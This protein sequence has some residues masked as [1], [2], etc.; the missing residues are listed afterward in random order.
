[1]RLSEIIKGTANV[2]DVVAGE[3]ITKTVKA[4][5]SGAEATISGLERASENYIEHKNTVATQVMTE[6]LDFINSDEEELVL[7]KRLSYVLKLIQE[8]GVR[9]EKAPKLFTTNRFSFTVNGQ[10]VIIR[11]QIMSSSGFS[12][13]VILKANEGVKQISATSNSEPEQVS[14]REKTE[15]SLDNYI[16]RRLEELQRTSKNFKEELDK[17]NEKA[18][19]IPSHTYKKIINDGYKF[20]SKNIVRKN[21]TFDDYTVKKTHDKVELIRNAEVIKIYII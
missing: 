16:D 7:S 9:V 10:K 15:E 21:G 12:G 19:G 4:I 11:D 13:A 3:A 18:Y 14:A 8:Q 6:I 17:Q 5:G 2:I 20:L 1:M